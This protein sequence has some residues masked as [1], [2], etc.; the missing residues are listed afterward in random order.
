VVSAINR[1]SLQFIWQPVPD[2]SP[3]SL[4]FTNV[5][6]NTIVNVEPAQPIEIKIGYNNDLPA[7]FTDFYSLGTAVG[8]DDYRNLNGY[9]RIRNLVP[10]TGSVCGQEIRMLV[11]AAAGDNMEFFDPT[12]TVSFEG[13]ILRFGSEIVMSQSLQSG[14]VG[15]DGQGMISIDLVPSSGIYPIAENLAG[16]C[17]RSIRALCQKPSS[18][19]NDLS[20]FYDATTGVIN[21]SMSPTEDRCNSGN[22]FKY[23]GSMFLGYAGSVRSKVIVA[24]DDAIPIFDQAPAQIPAFVDFPADVGV[25]PLG[26]FNPIFT[27]ATVS[28][29]VL[30]PYYNFETYRPASRPAGD[31]SIVWRYPE[32]VPALMQYYRSAGPDAR[33][34]YF[35]AQNEFFIADRVPVEPLV[36]FEPKKVDPSLLEAKQVT[37][38]EEDKTLPMYRARTG[39]TTRKFSERVR[40]AK[41]VAAARLATAQPLIS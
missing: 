23:F 12:E 33:Y 25:M 34:S 40:I 7:C 35:R 16:E 6:I 15:D 39:R 38:S 28:T 19:C 4:D 27:D 37:L 14:I 8:P 20:T 1:G 5:S 21:V 10:F 3:E 22:Y 13:E 32:A 18:A 24:R 9:L 17:V 11:F 30:I 41:G 29:D 26:E 31:Y 2:S 36:W